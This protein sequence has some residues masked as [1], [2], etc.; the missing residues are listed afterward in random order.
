[1]CLPFFFPLSL[2]SK[3]LPNPSHVSNGVVFRTKNTGTSIS[4][5]DGEFK[6]IVGLIP[7]FTIFVKLEPG[8]L[9]FDNLLR[10][11]AN[12]QH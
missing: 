9:V 2:F 4:N 12:H 5:G 6:P 10:V 11:I 1:M 7:K 8:L 3:V